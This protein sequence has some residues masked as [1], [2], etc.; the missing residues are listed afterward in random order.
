MGRSLAGGQ[1]GATKT[2]VGRGGACRCNWKE[3]ELLGPLLVAVQEA[4]D[5]KAVAKAILSGA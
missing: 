5:I 3:A 1:T 2:S 4:N